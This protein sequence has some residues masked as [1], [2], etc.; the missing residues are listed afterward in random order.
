MKQ[1]LYA[2]KDELSG[3]FYQPTTMENDE[4]AKRQFKTQV[5]GIELWK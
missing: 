4:I 2:V 5:N 1:T 3:N